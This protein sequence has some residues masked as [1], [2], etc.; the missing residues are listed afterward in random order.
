MTA[1]RDADLRRVEH[2]VGVLVRRVKRV[3]A[4]RARLLHPDLQP[5]TFLLLSHV[6]EQGPLRAADMVGAFGM[7]KGGVSRQVQH[8]VDLGLVDR[9][10]DP[11]DR[12]AALLVATDDAVRRVQEMQQVRRERFDQRL[13]D[14][15]DAELARFADQLASYNAALADD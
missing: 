13:G 9:Q 5:L 8:L 10:P 2:E 12:R 7:D 1:E 6:M 15:S 14:W 11:D 4:E 3:L